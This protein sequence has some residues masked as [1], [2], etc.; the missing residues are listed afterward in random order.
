MIFKKLFGR[1]R[2]TV[3]PENIKDI[4][5]ITNEARQKVMEEFIDA[6][7]P[8]ISKGIVSR[9]R[10]GFND[11]TQICEEMPSYFE[12]EMTVT[13]MVE[14]LKTNFPRYNFRLWF[15]GCKPPGDPDLIVSVS[16]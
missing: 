15:K 2:G 9:A 6:L 7:I 4:Q 13:Y 12:D 16:W 10:D 8:Q 3:K 1:R 14:N 11:Y 5:I